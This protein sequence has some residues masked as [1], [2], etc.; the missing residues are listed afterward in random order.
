MPSNL[1]NL[2]VILDGQKLSP[3]YLQPAPSGTAHD[4]LI[5]LKQ[6]FDPIQLRTNPLPGMNNPPIVNGRPLANLLFSPAWIGSL[7]V[8]QDAIFLDGVDGGLDLSQQRQPAYIFT[9][10][11]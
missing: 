7:A 3:G 10:P 11:V 1:Q 4:T 6:Q 9:K 8:G 2:L 5:A